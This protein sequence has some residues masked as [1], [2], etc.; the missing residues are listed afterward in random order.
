V[1][2]VWTGLKCFRYVE[3]AGCSAHAKELPSSK[4]GVEHSQLRK[5]YRHLK[6]DC[7]ALNYL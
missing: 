4:N 6:D 3:E 5:K 2:E 7:G 1:C